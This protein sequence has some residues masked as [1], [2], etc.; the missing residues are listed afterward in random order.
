M[1]GRSRTESHPHL[2]TTVGCNGGGWYSHPIVMLTLSALG[3]GVGDPTWGIALLAILVVIVGG[4]GLG[5][6]LSR[7]R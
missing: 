6:L 1:P 5:I 2:V 7:K 3:F 4:I